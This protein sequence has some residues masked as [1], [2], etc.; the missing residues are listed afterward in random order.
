[1]DGLDFKVL[2]QYTNWVIAVP[3]DGIYQ[4]EVYN[5]MGHRL[6]SERTENTL[7]IPAPEG[8]VVI[9]VTDGFER[10]ASRVVM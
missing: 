10:S 3:N 1:M 9:R 5:L 2:K 8:A 6:V 7:T 4:V